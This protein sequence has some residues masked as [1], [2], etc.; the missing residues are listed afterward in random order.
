MHPLQ[1]ICTLDN[2]TSFSQSTTHLTNLTRTSET[3]IEKKFTDLFGDS[4]VYSWENEN[5][6]VPWTYLIMFFFMSSMLES[7]SP[8]TMD[9]LVWSLLVLIMLIFPVFVAGLS[10]LFG[11]TYTYVEITVSVVG[12]ILVAVGIVGILGGVELR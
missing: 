5:R 10:T 7:P 1:T 2:I 4:P 8:R 12:G 9:L 6:Y 3:D 11:A